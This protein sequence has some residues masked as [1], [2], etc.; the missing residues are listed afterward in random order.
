MGYC[1]VE[2]VTSRTEL[3]DIYTIGEAVDAY[4]KRQF[5]ELRDENPDNPAMYVYMSDGW[6]TFVSSH[7]SVQA[8]VFCLC[9]V[10]GG[11]V[12]V[13]IAMESWEH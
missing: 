1:K 2:R 7:T 4:H 13:V 5:R 8:E 11:E 12:P 9:G 10:A 6:G 3:D